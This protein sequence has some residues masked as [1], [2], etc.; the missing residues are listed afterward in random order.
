MRRSVKTGL[1][2][3]VIAGVLGGTAAWASAPSAK[4]IA[5]QIDGRSQQVHTT[6]SN[7]SGVL[8]SA[9]VSVG[10]HDLVAPDQNAKINNGGTIV[11][12]RGHLLHLNVDGTTR[13]VWV[14][15]DSVADALAQLGY[16]SD[17]LVS[18]SRSKRLDDGPTSLTISSP[19][20][21]TFLVDH[22]KL[23]VENAG[24]TV[25][26]AIKANHIYLYPHDR[27]SVPVASPVK[28]NEV[29][30]IS[31]FK[32][33][34]V[35]K[36]EAIPY[37]TVTQDDPSQ[38]V[39]TNS[40]V[41]PGQP[42]SKS[43]TYQ[44]VYIDG[45]LSG[46]IVMASKTLSQPTTQVQKNGTKQQPAP[47][48][49]ASSGGGNTGATPPASTSGL[50][51]DAV[52]QCESGGNWAIN[53]GNGFYGGLQ[54]DYGTWLSNGGGAY[55]PRADLATREQQIAIANKLYAARGASPWPVCGQRL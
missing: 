32:Y 14:N 43:V 53:T 19:K 38:Y 10:S 20:R 27:V 16:G 39:G 23:V 25:L 13:D 30:R 3:L 5:L 41:T 26:D 12:R 6:A 21:I 29:I 28:Q 37:T 7:V 11:I 9:K 40:V 48:P 55:A 18:V 4:T 44:L 8:K 17:N 42:G 49:A 51:W 33:V 24:P 54:F 47:P 45:T 46:R 50:N 36:T 22:K 35:T 2:G 31:R 1:Y 34:T 15:A 52:A